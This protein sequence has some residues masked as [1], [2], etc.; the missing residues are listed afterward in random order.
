MN[1]WEFKK[2]GREPNGQNSSLYGVCPVSTASNADGIHNGKNGGRCCWAIITTEPSE[3][4]KNLGFCCGGLSEC[5]Q[6]DF[7]QHV[8]ESTELVIAV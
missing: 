4:E 6:C 5:I 7:Y 1:C 3:M 8:K 2:C